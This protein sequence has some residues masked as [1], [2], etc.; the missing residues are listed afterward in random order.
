[1]RLILVDLP[2]PKRRNFDPL[3][4]S[5]PIWE[6]RCGMTTLGEKLVSRAG[7]ADVA[8]FV[9]PYMAEA[10]RA[11]T[12]RPVN[13]LDSLADDDLLLACGRVKA[14]GVGA[15]AAGP[16]R[17]ACDADGELLL[18]RVARD[19]ILRLDD[20]SIEGF[21][22]SAKH[23]LPPADVELPT[24]NY[25]WDLILANREQLVEDFAAAGRSGIEGTVEQPNAIRGSAKDVYVAPGALVHPMVVIDATGGPV[26]IDEGAEIHPFTRIEGPC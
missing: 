1:M 14:D 3:G 8:C 16:S 24:W 20:S 10:Y 12:S 18:A 6:L 26:Y 7:T 4:L 22:D 2:T 23:M 19:D 5:R 15:F 21:L 25:T 11:R 17:V 9:P 13:D